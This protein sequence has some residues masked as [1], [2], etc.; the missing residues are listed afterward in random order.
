[1]K[2][3]KTR[4]AKR[5]SDTAR[6]VRELRHL[7]GGRRSVVR[8]MKAA[9]SSSLKR[10]EQRECSPIKAHVRAV[11]ETYSRARLMSRV[12]LKKLRRMEEL[13]AFRSRRK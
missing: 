13:V 2:R 8:V 7:L 3:R 5:K 12:M 11:D 6:K 1:M 10:W 9:S 4:L